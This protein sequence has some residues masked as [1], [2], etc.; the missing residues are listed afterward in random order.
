MAKRRL[1]WKFARTH[2]GDKVA[3]TTHLSSSASSSLPLLVP[4]CV[5]N[6]LLRVIQGDI[7]LYRMWQEGAN[8]GIHPLATR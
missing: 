5:F 1:M 3:S 7:F 8:D 4:F 2:P 6:S